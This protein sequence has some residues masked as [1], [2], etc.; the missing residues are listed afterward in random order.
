MLKK[1][2]QETGVE[3]KLKIP[4]FGGTLTGASVTW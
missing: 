3:I 4:A 1:E 2:K